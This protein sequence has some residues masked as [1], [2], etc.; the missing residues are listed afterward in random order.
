[1]VTRTREQHLKNERYTEALRAVKQSDRTAEGT[2]ARRAGLA[3]RIA[4][5]IRRGFLDLQLLLSS[6]LPPYGTVFRHSND[7]SPKEQAEREIDLTGF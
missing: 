3:R 4:D 6:F 1:M 5:G 2:Q 7:L